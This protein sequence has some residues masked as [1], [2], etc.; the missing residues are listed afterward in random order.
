MRWKL[1]FTE[2]APAIEVARLI[3]QAAAGPHLETWAPPSWL[4]P[5]QVPAAQKLAACLD[6][7]TGAL[8]ADAVGLGKTY[9]ALGIA[10]RYHRVT[11]VVPAA[12]RGQWTVHRG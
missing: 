1:A 6:L 2:Q 4:L 9:V 3:E 5:H 11:A 7:F 10:T 8:L 12:L